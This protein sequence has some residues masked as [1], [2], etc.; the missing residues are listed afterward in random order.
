[1]KVHGYNQQTN[2]VFTNRL[3]KTFSS[4]P[5]EEQAEHLAFLVARGGES[6]ACSEWVLG[7]EVLYTAV[8][9]THP[10]TGL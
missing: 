5:N 10:R 9:E 1:M 2:T 8:S 4:N 7:S 6:E 3:L